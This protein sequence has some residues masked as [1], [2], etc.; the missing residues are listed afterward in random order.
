MSRLGRHELISGE[1][2]PALGMKC[3]LQES[4]WK[5][6]PWVFGG[7]AELPFMYYGKMGWMGFKS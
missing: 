1:H 7:P 5:F 4:E 2:V 6:F 3:R